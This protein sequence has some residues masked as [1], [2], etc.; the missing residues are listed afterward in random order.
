[1]SQS[2]T[3]QKLNVKSVNNDINTFLMEYDSNDTKKEYLRDIK[4]F[5][6]FI[7]GK[8]LNEL[9]KDD[10][11]HVQG[12]KMLKNHIIPYVNHLLQKNAPDTVNRKLSTL[13]ALYREFKGYGYDVDNSIFSVKIPKSTS[14]GYDVLRSDEIQVMAEL[15]KEER[16]QGD[17]LHC[18]ILLSAVTSIRVDAL[19][20][21]ELKDINFDSEQEYYTVKT[22]DKR[23]TLVEKPFEKDLYEKL[24]KIERNGSTKLFPDLKVDKI[25]KTIKRLALKMGLSDKLRIVTHSLRKTA[26]T[27]EANDSGSIVKIMDQLGTKS[28]VSAMRYAK[29]KT[30]YENLAG[31]KMF[32]KVD[33]SVFGLME[34]DELLALLKETNINAYNQLALKL[35]SIVGV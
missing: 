35:M 5:F 29:T 6:Q 32:K 2:A 4:E 28:A 30:K 15:A 31:I 9:T 26:A 22:I 10:I 1:M 20:S 12:D 33:E 21:V 18:F 23:Q 13:K 8:E 3:V 11:S 17:Q 7:H 25:N 34:K 27:W 24:M 19:L 14:T 16:Y